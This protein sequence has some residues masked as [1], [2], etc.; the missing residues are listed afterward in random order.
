MAPSISALTIGIEP[1]KSGPRTG[2]KIPDGIDDRKLEAAAF[3]RDKIPGR[4][5]GERLRLDIGPHVAR[6]RIGPVVSSNGCVLR[7]VA[8]AD[9]RRTRMSSPR[10][11]RRRRARR[12][13]RERSFTRGDN[14]FVLVLGDAAEAARR[15]AAR[16]RSPPRRAPAGVLLRSAAKNEGSIGRRRAALPQHRAHI[17]SPLRVDARWCAPDGPRPE[18][19]GRRGCRQS[20]AAGDQNQAHRY[21]LSPV[22]RRTEIVRAGPVKTGI[23]GD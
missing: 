6:H 9:R 23:W 2:P 3:P 22:G 20:R 16:S 13:A 17:A 10:A 14:Q 7:L 18:A 12:A 19:A 1:E 8:K 21:C 11:S 15:R 4:A 5:F